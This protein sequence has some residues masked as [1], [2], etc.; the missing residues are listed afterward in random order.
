MTDTGTDTAR[1]WI[2]KRKSNEMKNIHKVDETD[3]WYSTGG[4][5]KTFPGA[6]CVWKTIKGNGHEKEISGLY[7][8]DTGR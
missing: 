4:Y 7:L 8:F 3:R 1:K 5:A 2:V 6:F